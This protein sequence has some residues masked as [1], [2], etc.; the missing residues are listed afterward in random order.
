[1]KDFEFL[2]K[3]H[4]LFDLKHLN[5]TVQ[6][7]LLVLFCIGGKSNSI[8]G[9]WISVSAKTSHL[10]LKTVFE[11]KYPSRRPLFPTPYLG[12]GKEALMFHRDYKGT[13]FSCPVMWKMWDT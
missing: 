6:S 13:D 4:A 10:K 9:I 7:D 3:L 5:I 12:Y 2:C 1:M 8:S 11:Q